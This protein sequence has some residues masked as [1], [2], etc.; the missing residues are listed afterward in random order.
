MRRVLALAACFAALASTG[1]SFA[2]SD[3]HYRPAR[4]HC[5]GSDDNSDNSSYVNPSCKTL[6]MTLSDFGGHAYIGAGIPQPADGNFAGAMDFWVDPGNGQKATWSLS[7]DG[8][9]A[10]AM[11][12]SDEPAAN[13]TTGLR[14]YFGADDNL[15]GG[16][17]D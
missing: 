8:F 12:A 15:D 2:V 7:Q 9:G 1:T 11:T 6:I 17:H 14:L 13:P 5:T 10:P 16:E 3:G 4:N